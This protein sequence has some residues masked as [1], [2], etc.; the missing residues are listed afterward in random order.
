MK[1]RN[2][3]VIAVGLFGLLLCACAQQEP[4]NTIATATPTVQT[5]TETTAPAE[6]GTR[7]AFQAALKTIHDDLFWPDMDAETGKIEIFEPSTIEDEQFAICDVDGDGEEELLVSVSNTYMAGMRLAVYGYDAASGGL[8]GNRRLPR[9]DLLP[10]HD[11]DGVLPQSG[12]RRGR[13]LALW[14]ADL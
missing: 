5:T 13:A 12:P 1:K 9:R 8:R 14:R 4:A 7:E 6:N 11:E 10:R 3:A 2:T